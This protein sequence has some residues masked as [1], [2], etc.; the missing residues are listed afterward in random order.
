MYNINFYN[1]KLF[2]SVYPYPFEYKMYKILKGA[3]IVLRSIERILQILNFL[4][5]SYTYLRI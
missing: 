4:Y 2:S 3:I 5:T 1:T